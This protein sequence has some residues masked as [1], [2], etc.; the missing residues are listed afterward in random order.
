MYNHIA[1]QFLKDFD[2]TNWSS[3]A[4]TTAVGTYYS[5]PI[6]IN[7]SQGF[8]ALLV[9]TSAGSLA[10]TFEVSDNGGTFYTP[11]DINGTSLNTIASALTADT[12]ISFSPQIA[13]WIRFKFILTSS[14]STVTAKYMFLEDV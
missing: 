11:K 7:H 9:L 5:E 14:N 12:W 3:K 8:N 2:G 6:K 1:S 13:R 4:M 10:I